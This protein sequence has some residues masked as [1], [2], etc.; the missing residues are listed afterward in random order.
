MS[1]QTDLRDL[2]PESATRE[3]LWRQVTQRLDQALDTLPERSPMPSLDM[4]S[5][6]QHLES[7]DFSRPQDAEDVLDDVVDFLGRGMVQTQHPR[8]FGLFNP[9]PTFPSI[10]ADTITAALNPQLAVWTHAPVA[11]EIERHVVRTLGSWIG[12]EEDATFGHFTSGGAEANYT[13]TLLALTRA[14][15]HFADQGS[16]SFVGRPLIYASEES[17]LAW[18][19]IAHQTGIGRKAVRLVPTDGSGRMD[20]E[21]LRLMVDQDQASGCVPVMVAATAGTT[22]AGMIDPLLPIRQIATDYGLW[23]HVDA[24]WGGAICVSPMHRAMMSGIETSDSI[25]LDAHKW[26]FQ[27]FE[28]GCL[29]VRDVRRLESAVSVH[30]EYLQDTDWGREHVNFADRG[31]QLTRSFRAL[32]VWM[33]IQTFGM[34]AFRR[35][36]EKGID[37]A[38]RAAEFIDASET[39]EMLSPARLGVVCFRANP[40]GTGLDDAALETLNE[41]VQTRIIHSKVAMMSSTRL[42]GTYSLR[43]CILNH[44]TTWEDVEMTLRAIERYAVEEVGTSGDAPPSVGPGE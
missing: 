42:R 28:A 29:M 39:L 11:V 38:D 26:L 36:V 2:L 23:Y 16:T 21:A 12:W 5:I 44:H 27:P 3:A 6:R 4:P 33:S 13:A 14:E 8:Y 15:P 40:P 41:R 43:L 34:A 19:K 7:Y 10:L 20:A 32:K 25:T 17:H 22:N 35:A 1:D 9:S 24:A 18:F 37:F 31:L 30:P